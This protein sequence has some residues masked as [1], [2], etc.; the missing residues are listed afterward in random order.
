MLVYFDFLKEFIFVI[1]VFDYGVGVVLFYKVEGG[2]EWLIGYMFRFFNV[3][4]RNYLIF[5]KEVFV[6][7]FGVKKF[8]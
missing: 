3:V 2:V 1:D 8:N 4:E 5:E 7:I 6:I